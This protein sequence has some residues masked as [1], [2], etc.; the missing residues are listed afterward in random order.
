VGIEECA[1]VLTDRAVA[2]HLPPSPDRRISVNETD[3][4]SPY[5][6]SCHS[7]HSGCAMHGSG[8]SGGW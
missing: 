5:R 2:H 6:P 4:R 7:S 1:K 8:W 3:T